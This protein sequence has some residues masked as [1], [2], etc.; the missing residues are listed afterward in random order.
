MGRR[1]A[2]AMGANPAFRVVAA[3]DPAPDAASAGLPMLASAEAV[4][5]RPDV[6]CVYIASPPRWHRTHVEAVAAVRKP[7]FCEKP[8]AASLEEAEAICAA[9]RSAGVPAG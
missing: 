7:V 9:V 4:A 2:E 5:E 8:L 1:M 3:F 6:Q